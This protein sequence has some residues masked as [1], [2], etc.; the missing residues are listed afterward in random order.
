M[1]VI[2]GLTEEAADDSHSLEEGLGEAGSEAQGAAVRQPQDDG[3]VLGPE[4]E[5][6]VGQ[7][8]VLVQRPVGLQ[9]PLS[10]LFPPDGVVRPVLLALC[11][12]TGRWGHTSAPEGPAPNAEHKPRIQRPVVASPP[13]SKPRAGPGCVGLGSRTKVTAEWLFAG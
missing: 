6:G 13:L 1:G 11:G 10:F 9:Q 12:A 8:A 3:P 7:D 5:A 2:W 4:E